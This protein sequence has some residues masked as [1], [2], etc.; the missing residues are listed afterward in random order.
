MFEDIIENYDDKKLDYLKNIWQK[1]ISKLILEEDEKKILSFLN[2]SWIIQ[3]DDKSQKVFVWLS[4]EFF[5]A[6]VKKI[7]QKSLNKV[8]KEVYNPS[9]SVAFTVFDKFQSWRHP[10]QLNLQ[11]FLWTKKTKTEK[12]EIQHTNQDNTSVLTKFSKNKLDYSYRFD[13]FVVWRSSQLAYSAAMA[14][15]ENLGKVHNPLFIYGWV[16]LWKTHLLQAI[17]NYVTQNYKN[18]VVLYMQTTN[19]ID[20]IVEAIRKNKVNSFVKQFKD[21]D[22]I[23]FDDIQFLQ[24]KE[25][26]QE[27]FH[28]IFNEFYSWKKQ[29][30]LTSD[31]PPKELVTLQARLRSRFARGF[32]VDIKQPD[33]ETK[34][35]IL[36]KK[37]IEKW[38]ENIS[39]DF[40]E[41]IWKAITNNIRELEW[42]LNLL[43]TRRKMFGDLQEQDVYD[44]LETLW[45]KKNKSN[46]ISSQ[47][48]SRQ[49]SKSKKN[50]WEIVEYVAN[51]YDI[52]VND[53]KGKSRRKEISQARQMLMMIGKKHFD[54]TLEKIWTYFW[55]KNHA[56]VLYSINTFERMLKNDKKIYNDYMIITEETML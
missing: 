49:N 41:I 25:R 31:R 45:Y 32:V 7:F 28:N 16:W 26:T 40:L 4:N 48:A 14:V 17:W 11:K 23:I 34:I 1:V 43:I 8:V 21:V 24:D 56:S 27:I 3:I 37:L 33:L 5:V 51:Y 12:T 36:Q 15:A 42:A 22:I 2:K 47:T 10:L 35:A 9:F 29:I 44:S 13:T 6:Q 50:F 52:P 39:M 19:L 46:T 53:I 54:R 30:V 18:K 55:W 20:D 38:E